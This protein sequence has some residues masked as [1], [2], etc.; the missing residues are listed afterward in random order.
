MKFPELATHIKNHI[1]VNAHE[2][3]VFFKFLSEVSVSEKSYLITPNTQIRHSFF[4]IK[5]C[6]KSYYTDNKGDK[7]V[8]QFAIE[9]WWISDFEAFYQN[10]PTKLTIEAVEPSSLLAISKENLEALLLEAPIFERYFRILLTNA[11]IA[12]RKR[13]LSSLE[14][15]TKE[16]YLEFCDSYPNI[17]NRVQNY[18]IANYLGVSAES[19]SRIRGSLKC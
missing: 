3:E 13:V 9:N 12:Q 11:F 4:V 1:K 19:L 14:K 18:H 2:I 5:G 16:R 7:H 15:N 6:L 8:M 10:E 17:E